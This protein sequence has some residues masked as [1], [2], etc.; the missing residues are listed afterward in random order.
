MFLSSYRNIRESLGEREML[1]EHEPPASVYTA[2]SSSPKLSWMF[3]LPDR[4]TE[5]MF[6][7]SCRKYRDAKKE[8]QLVYFD[9]QNVNSLC[10]R[11][12]I[13]TCERNISHHCWAQHVARVWPPWWVVLR[14]VGCCLLKFDHLEPTIP[15]ISRPNT[16]NMLRP[17]ML[18][19]VRLTC[20]D[21]LPG[22]LLRI[23][24]AR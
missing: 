12:T 22:A 17:T 15:K 24:R 14:H 8:N 7:I 10:S 21:R 6:S 4:N 9:H 1:W 23:E 11:Q 19:Y 18:R 16:R 2:F 20:C 5:N 13:T 3:L